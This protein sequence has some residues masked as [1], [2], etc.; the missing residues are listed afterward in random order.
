M[1]LLLQ[2]ALTHV[3]HHRLKTFNNNVNEDY[4]CANK[5]NHS[6]SLETRHNAQWDINIKANNDNV[7][8]LYHHFVSITHEDQ[9]H[10][11][12]SVNIMAYTRIIKKYL[13]FKF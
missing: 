9:I 11:I 10:F 6:L 12:Q 4:C 5:R 8:C 1:T 2:C 3:G 13:M 7:T